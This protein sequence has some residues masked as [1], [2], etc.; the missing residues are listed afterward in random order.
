M[1]A[2]LDLRRKKGLIKN[3]KSKIKIKKDFVKILRTSSVSS[4]LDSTSS[5]KSRKLHL[6]IWIPLFGAGKT[7]SGVPAMLVLVE[8]PLQNLFINTLIVKLSN[9]G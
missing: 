1:E 7:T 4:V 5:S 9:D 8:G 2:A 3:R 6:S